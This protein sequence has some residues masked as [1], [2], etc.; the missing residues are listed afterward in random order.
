MTIFSRAMIGWSIGVPRQLPIVALTGISFV[1]LGVVVPFL[2][3][4]QSAWKSWAKL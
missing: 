2:D 4:F 3:L 1:D